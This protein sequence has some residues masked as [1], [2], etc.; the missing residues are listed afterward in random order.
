MNEGPAEK[1]I[2][3]L[4]RQYGGC[5][6]CGHEAYWRERGNH[7]RQIAAHGHRRNCFRFETR[8]DLPAAARQM[9]AAQLAGRWQAPP[10]IAA[11]RSAEKLAKQIG[12]GVDRRMAA[13][14]PERV[15]EDE[16]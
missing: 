10:E 6:A 11:V 1:R 14:E 13:A 7:V 3:E 9:E 16:L 5:G 8:P 12:R 15:R 4:T 2:R